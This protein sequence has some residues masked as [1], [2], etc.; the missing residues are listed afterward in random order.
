MFL[1]VYSVLNNRVF[2]DNCSH[3]LSLQMR[4]SELLLVT[5]LPCLVISSLYHTPEDCPL[6]HINYDPKYGL[7]NEEE[8]YGRWCHFKFLNQVNCWD[9]FLSHSW[10][11]TPYSHTVT[12]MQDVQGQQREELKN[13]DLFLSLS[14]ISQFANIS[15]KSS[16]KGHYFIFIN[17]GFKLSFRQSIATVVPKEGGM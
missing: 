5:L 3:N 9:F 7:I 14:P 2:Y 13:C 8:V 15:F 11:I 10:V 12:R 6:H 4:T 16:G 1:L 17:I